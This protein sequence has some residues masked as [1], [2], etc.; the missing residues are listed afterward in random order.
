MRRKGD[1]NKDKEK[2]NYDK[3]IEGENRL[4]KSEFHHFNFV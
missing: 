3:N 4:N 1:D 2:E